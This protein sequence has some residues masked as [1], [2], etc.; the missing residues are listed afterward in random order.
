MSTVPVVIISGL[1]RR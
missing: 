1:Y